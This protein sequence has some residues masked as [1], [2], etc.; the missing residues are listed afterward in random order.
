MPDRT[1]TAI[2]G[3][4]FNP[5]HNGHIAIARKVLIAGLA[6]ELWMMVTPQNPWKKNLQLMDDDVRLQMVQRAVS[7]IPGV[8]AS[9]FEF[10][11]PK[12]SYTAN[13]LR[14]LC[15]SYPD[16]EFSL[17]IGAD[18]WEKFGMWFDHDYILRNFRTIVYPR[19]GFILPSC[20]EGDVRIL[21]CPLMDISSTEIRRRIMS[22]EDITGLVPEGMD[23]LLALYKTD[24][25][26]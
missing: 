13:T 16:R 12:P 15:E 3:G 2:F 22:G 10:S 5:V 4:T 26:G 9:D 14:R 7:S 1:R 24:R 20:E 8:E 21:D 17:V 18:N 25:I 11:L 6:D 19:P 23:D